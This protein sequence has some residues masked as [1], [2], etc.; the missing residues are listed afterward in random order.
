MQIVCLANGNT[1]SVMIDVNTTTISLQG[2]LDVV[3]S[4]F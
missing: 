4:C 2:M 1:K 3:E